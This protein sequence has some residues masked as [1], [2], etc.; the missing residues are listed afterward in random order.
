MPSSRLMFV[1][2]K[3]N[4][5]ELVEIMMANIKKKRWLS[6]SSNYFSCGF[7][8]EAEVELKFLCSNNKISLPIQVALML[9]NCKPILSNSFIKC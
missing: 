2:R 8:L 4:S 9:M 3:F 6:L 5:T 1:C 7:Q